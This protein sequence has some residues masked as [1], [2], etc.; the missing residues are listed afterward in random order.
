M[1]SVPQAAI[2]LAKRF[3]GFRGVPKNDPGRAYPYICPAGFWTI[4]YGRLCNPKHSPITEAEGAAYLGQDLM[5]ALTATLRY[6]PVLAT[7]SNLRL[8]GSLTLLS[9]LVQGVCK[10][11]RSGDELISGTGTG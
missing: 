7:E 1:T 5:T 9:I 6:C 2:D 8:A 10:H 3:E 11:Q 4:G